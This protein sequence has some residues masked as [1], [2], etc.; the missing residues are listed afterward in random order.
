MLFFWINGSFYAMAFMM[1]YELHS[2]IEV[3]RLGLG[4]FWVGFLEK[5]WFECFE[6]VFD[7]LDLILDW[8]FW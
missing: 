2:L 6:D 7:G 8:L 5:D 3:G 4:N 1:D